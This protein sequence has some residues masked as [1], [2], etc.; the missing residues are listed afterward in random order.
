MQVLRKYERRDSNITE[1]ASGDETKK[2]EL[3]LTDCQI[4]S[5]KN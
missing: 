5:K 4:L 3:C 2:R 1:F